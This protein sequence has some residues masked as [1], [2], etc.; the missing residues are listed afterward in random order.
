MVKKSIEFVEVRHAA[1]KSA[2]P[3][4]RNIVVMRICPHFLK[5]PIM[6]SDFNYSN[7]CI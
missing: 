2:P 5:P 4:E 1:S 6:F 3:P 7:L